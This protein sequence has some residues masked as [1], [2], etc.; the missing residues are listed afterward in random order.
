MFSRRAAY[1]RYRRQE[2]D[3]EVVPGVSPIKVMEY[4]VVRVELFAEREP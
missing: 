1:Y 3:Q 4:E 2:I